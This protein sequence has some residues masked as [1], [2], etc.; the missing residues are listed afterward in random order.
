M[1]IFTPV[2]KVINLEDHWDNIHSN[3]YK[4]IIFPGALKSHCYSKSRK[5]EQFQDRE[6]LQG[7]NKLRRGK[8]YPRIL[9]NVYSN[10][11]GHGLLNSLAKVVNDDKRSGEVQGNAARHR[12]ADNQNPFSEVCLLAS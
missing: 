1:I 2:Y 3:D 10:N 11:G 4:V 5:G 8:N 7:R 6:E 9:H 12:P